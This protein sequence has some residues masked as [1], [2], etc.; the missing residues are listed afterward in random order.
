MT[1][2]DTTTMANKQAK[3]ARKKQNKKKKTKGITGSGDY[4]LSGDMAFD[5]ALQ[6]IDKRLNQ[7][8]RHPPPGQPKS[9]VGQGA[10]ILGRLAGNFLGGPSGGE[11][12][13]QAA[14]GLA[15][16]LGHGDYTLTTNSLIGKPPSGEGMPKFDKDGSRG[17]RICEREYLGDI[18]SGGTLVNGSSTF[19]LRGFAL[20]PGVATTFPWLA[21]I[22]QQY[23]AYKPN[24]IIF[25]FKSTSSAFNGT[26]QALGTVICATDYDPTD[27]YYINKTQMEAADYSDST[28]A[29]KSMMHGIECEPKERGDNVLY[30][31]AGGIPAN[32]NLR[33]YD[34]GIFQIATQ[35][36]SATNVNLGELWV[37][38]DFTFYKKNLMNGILG[39]NVTYNVMTN[40]VAE[41]QANPLG[42]PRVYGNANC[43]IGSGNVLRF[44]PTISTGVFLIEYYAEATGFAGGIGFTAPVNCEDLPPTTFTPN[45]SIN[46][47]ISAVVGKQWQRQFV[48]VTGRNASLTLTLSGAVTAGTKAELLVLQMNGNPSIT[49]NA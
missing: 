36:M 47:V 38:Y 48:R 10:G 12:G 9:L 18:F 5:D 7:L 31:R 11:L 16:F 26:S 44:D 39:F 41:T 37:S 42:T 45:Y 34:L 13:H 3:A 25:E 35:G 27:A 20:N 22:A 32:D 29:Y 15:R 30:V 43:T 6:D 40:T 8:E 17:T 4:D 49:V 21:S 1:T 33:F 23:E 46:Q 28:S 14:T 24:G 19:D 2:S